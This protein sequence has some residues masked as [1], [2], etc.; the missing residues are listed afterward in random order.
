MNLAV[1]LNRQLSNRG[2]VDVEED[3]DR[4]RIVPQAKP[5]NIRAAGDPMKLS[6]ILSQRPL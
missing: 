3:E 1:C 4:W 6:G 2:A 5:A